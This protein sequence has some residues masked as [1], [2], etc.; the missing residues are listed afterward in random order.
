MDWEQ[1]YLLTDFEARSFFFNSK[2]RYIYQ[3]CDVVLPTWCNEQVFWIE[4]NSTVLLMNILLAKKS[5][6]AD[7]TVILKW[8]VKS[9]ICESFA[10]HFPI[11]LNVRKVNISNRNCW[12]QHS[13]YQWT[14]VTTW[15]N[16]TRKI[17][18][19]FCD[20]SKYQKWIQ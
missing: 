5:R 18:N 1:I 4:R 15:S 17:S 12:I 14:S 20:I 7:S 11:Q 9:M 3:V 19:F 16:S 10:A 2:S 6:S 13:S 8:S